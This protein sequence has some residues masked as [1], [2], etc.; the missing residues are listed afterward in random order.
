MTFQEPGQYYLKIKTQNNPNGGD[1]IEVTVRKTLGSS[2][3][4]MVFGIIALCLGV[5]CNEI[6]NKTLLRI[7]RNIEWKKGW[8]DDD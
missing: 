2:I 8:N 6:R 4:H 3:P 5:L 1:P 7:F